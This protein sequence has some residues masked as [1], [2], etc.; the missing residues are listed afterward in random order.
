MLRKS[1][2]SDNL[3]TCDPKLLIKSRRFSI[4]PKKRRSSAMSNEPDSVI[5]STGNTT[6][7]YFNAINRNTFNYTKP[8]E[9]FLT[10]K[11]RSEH[12]QNNIQKQTLIT[13]KN[14]NPLHKLSLSKSCELFNKLMKVNKIYNKSQMSSSI[15]SHKNNVI[16]ISNFKNNFIKN[17]LNPNFRRNNRGNIYK[18]KEDYYINFLYHK[19]F[20]K[21]FIEH[22]IKYNVVDNKLN[23]FYA[24]NDAIFKEN[25][26]KR[27]IMLR[28]KGKP[29]KKL[30][31]NNSYVKDKLKEVKKKISFLKGVADYAF[32]SIILDRVKQ[33]NQMYR[34]KK[35]QNEKFLLPYQEIE[36]E[37]KL[38]NKYNEQLLN[39]AIKIESKY[40]IKRENNNL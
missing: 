23:I 12:V 11:L 37:V 14:I 18:S 34:L 27:N 19:I 10:H 33:K 25:M 17:S 35:K 3:Y 30:L 22:N 16:P 20:P 38:Y 6:F 5:L 4:E 24:E 40:N 28:K 8:K 21:I 1:I 13:S 31:V 7:D 29:I 2:S 26:N 32:P 9:S 36:E 15:D 39:E